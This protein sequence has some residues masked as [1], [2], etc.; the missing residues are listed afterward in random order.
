MIPILTST[1]IM[2]LI[3]FS[4]TQERIQQ[5]DYSW[6]SDSTPATFYFHESFLFSWLF[7]SLVKNTLEIYLKY[8]LLDIKW[9]HTWR[10]E[11]LILQALMYTLL[12]SNIMSIGYR[13]S[14]VKSCFF[15][16]LKNWTVKFWLFY[17]Y[18]KKISQS[19]AVH[20]K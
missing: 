19:L 5:N 9:N 7:W 4:S 16:F 2:H 11:W 3:T 8:P 20:F 18:P 14:L 15:F 17:S 12:M 6:S 13:Q 1:S 10:L